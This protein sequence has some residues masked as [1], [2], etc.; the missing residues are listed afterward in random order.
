[1][2]IFMVAT[3]WGNFLFYALIGLVLFVLV[4][5]VPN[6]TEVIT[7]FTLVFIYMIL[8]LE[9]LLLSLPRANLAKISARRIDEVT[10]HLDPE[11]LLKLFQTP[12][13][14]PRKDSN[15]CPKTPPKTIPE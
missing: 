12:T 5:D 7:G 3:S 14:Y 6:R 2:S 10:K 1:M 9:L 13:T 8:P 4:G 15:A 11:N